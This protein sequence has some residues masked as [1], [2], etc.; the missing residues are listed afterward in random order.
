MS[1][2]AA[3]N[4]KNWREYLTDAHLTQFKGILFVCGTK[5]CGYTKVLSFN[6]KNLALEIDRVLEHI[7]IFWA[8]SPYK[9]LCPKDQEKD[10]LPFLERDKSEIDF[11]VYEV[12]GDSPE[13]LFKR[14]KKNFW[15]ADIDSL[16]NRK[17]LPQAQKIKIL[18][19]DDSSLIRRIIKGCLKNEN[20]EVV[21]ETGDPTEVKGLIQSLKPDVMTLDIN[22]P[23][24]S[25]LDV[26]KD[27][28][29][30]LLIPTIV[31]S[32]LALDEGGLVLE[33]L[34]KGAFDYLQKPS[35]E[36][37]EEFKKAIEEKINCAFESQQ[38]TKARDIVV[39]RVFGAEALDPEALL[40][41]GA[42]T[43]GTEALK[44]IMKAM[45]DH[46][47]PTVIVQHIPPVFSKA[48]ADSLNRLVDFE[49]RE[50]KDGDQL[51]PDLILVAPGG[52]Q[53]SVVKRGQ[54]LY[55]KIEDIGPV[56]GHKPSVD[57]LFYSVEKIQHLRCVAAI[58]TGM[59]KDGANGITK[60]KKQGIHTIGQN[61][62]TC[63]VY[64]MPHRAKEMGGI[65]EELPLEQIPQ[66]LCRELKK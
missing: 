47:P 32:S 36:S 61:K 54:N 25:G 41:I 43:G 20:Y 40:C 15:V 14:E 19:V 45:P 42:S 44:K 56:S 60:L 51:R 16:H 10:L 4:S 6:P 63:V 31:I 18:V 2:L 34:E 64:G 52:Y 39:E 28:P 49:V 24:M 62:E 58:L 48:F 23:K 21:G 1:N 33:A 55:V 59:G 26:I 11:V 53:M 17:L 27:L 30:H 22:M 5:E 29:N 38:T 3:K 35:N 65:T 57:H 13:V 66:A 8:K 50:A 9:I 37:R 12:S 7:Q 46:I